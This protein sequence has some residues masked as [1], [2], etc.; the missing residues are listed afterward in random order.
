VWPFGV[1]LLNEGIEADL[2]LKAVHGRRVGCLLLE[3]EV[4]ALVSAVLG[5][6]WL[7]TLDLNPE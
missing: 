5:V 4:H 6:T 3:G 2:L 7:D 1:E